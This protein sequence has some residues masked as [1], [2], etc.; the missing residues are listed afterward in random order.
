MQNREAF[1]SR[2]INSVGGVVATQYRDDFINAYI[3][4]FTFDGVSTKVYFFDDAT[5][6]ENGG[7]IG[8]NVMMAVYKSNHK[9]GTLQGLTP[10]VGGDL[11]TFTKGERVIDAVMFPAIPVPPQ[12]NTVIRGMGGNNMTAQDF[13]TLLGLQSGDIQSFSDNGSDIEFYVGV[14]YSIP[15]GAFANT[16]LQAYIDTDGHVL[17]VGQQSIYSCLSLEEIHMP[18]AALIKTSA[19][20]LCA[21][22]TTYHL[23]NAVTI[24][25][26]AFYGNEALQSL[27]LPSATSLQDRCLGGCF[28]LSSLST[29]SVESLGPN[30]VENNSLL[31]NWSLPAVS[32][33]NKY[34]FDNWGGAGYTLT[35]PSAM[36]GDTA[37][38]ST[39][40]NGTTVIFI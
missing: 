31:M 10:P 38:V 6:T 12:P 21:L 27:S 30:V 23:P 22:A 35:V 17:S 37:I 18:N 25:G 19:F 16:G 7:T 2:A 1:L 36:T 3:N 28:A 4:N 15:N 29:D 39:Q 13:E 40:N 33:I 14:D 9:F 32:T 20:E 24:E 8:V 26:L 11:I 34:A 5:V